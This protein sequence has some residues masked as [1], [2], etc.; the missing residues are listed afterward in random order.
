VSAAACIRYPLRMLGLVAVAVAV[1]VGLAMVPSGAAHATPSVS[2]LTAQIKQQSQQFE[3]VVE[4]YDKITGD[5]KKT[6]AKIRTLDKEIRSLTGKVS[7]Q[8]KQV[9]ELAAQAYMGGGTLNAWNALL[10]YSGTDLTEGIATV[11][12]ISANQS[13]QVHD[14]VTAKKTLAGQ[15]DRQAALYR[16]QAQ[17]KKD[18]AGKKSNIEAKIV[19]LKKLRTQAYGQAQETANT[20][21]SSSSTASPTVHVSGN[22]GVA[23]NF[24]YSQLGKPYEWAAAG[25]DAYDCSGLTMA[26]WAQA[27]VSLPHNAAEQYN[28]IPHVSRSEIQPGDLVFYES[29]GHV[30]IYV[31]NNQ[32]IHAPTYGEVVK[33]SSIDMMPVYGI[34]RP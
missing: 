5:M 30:A 3:K 34:G 6:R 23:V 4:Q 24:A 7:T 17:Q 22:A 26:A 8:Q 13:R 12:R 33:V 27:G 2:D 28:A 16:K 31:G 19:K 20:S 14:L 25:P 11:D 32:V 18:L 10:N 15:H 9:G 1:A 21:S 29:L